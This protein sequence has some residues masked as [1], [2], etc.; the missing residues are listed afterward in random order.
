MSRDGSRRIPTAEATASQPP[1]ALC[2]AVYPGEGVGKFSRTTRG[3]RDYWDD[4]AVENAPWYVDTSIAYD[5]PDMERFLD[6]GRQIVDAAFVSAPVQPAGRE[7]AVE[8]GPG[9][10]RVALAMAGHFDRVIGIDVSK[11]MVE[12]ARRLVTNPAVTFVVGD[13]ASLQPLAD[14]SADL[15]YSFTVLQHIP[16]VSVVQGYVTEAARVLRPGGVTALQWNNDPHPLR[17]KT[18]AAL[19]SVGHRLGLPSRRDNR[20]ARA[21]FGS[22]VPTS[23]MAAAMRA[24]GLVVE[25]TRDEGT[26]F[27]W[28]WARKPMPEYGPTG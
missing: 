13:G 9:L 12:R 16:K 20:N 21:F 22:R 11:E 14:G 7:L 6:A 19:S 23:R 26:L 5:N 10:G 17:W 2:G 4:R 1:L 3:M 8:I 24:S 15:V 18:N 27:A 25:G 28:I